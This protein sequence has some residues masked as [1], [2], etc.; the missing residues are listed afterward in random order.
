[1]LVAN[2]AANSSGNRVTTLIVSIGLV[3]GDVVVSP[4]FDNGAA[5][6]SLEPEQ[7]FAVIRPAARDDQRPRNHASRGVHHE[8]ARAGNEDR[9]GVLDQ[10][11]HCDCPLLSVRFAQPPDY[12]GRLPNPPA[13]LSGLRTVSV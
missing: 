10:G 13:L 3:R 11:D 2:G 6:H 9:T 1:M 8:Q 4:C 12:A 7:P 5:A